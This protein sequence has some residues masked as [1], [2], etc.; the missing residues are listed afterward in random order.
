MN[1]LPKAGK[2]VV[3]LKSGDPMIFGR[4]GEELAALAAARIPVSIVPGITAAQG[5]AASLK[6]SLTLRSSARRVQF[7]TRHARRG[8]LPAGFDLM[9]L[10][11]PYA[12]T[13]AF[14]PPGT[15]REIV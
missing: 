4:A 10:A 8:Q 2:R 14:M 3:R 6:V 13:A 7:I 12:T 15:F 9:G 11:E 1:G 5:A